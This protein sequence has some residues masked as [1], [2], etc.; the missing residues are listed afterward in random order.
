MDVNMKVTVKI[1]GTVLEL[2]REQ[3][4]ELQSRLAQQLGQVA[5]PIPYQPPWWPSIMPPAPTWIGPTTPAYT[6]DRVYPPSH[7]IC[8]TSQ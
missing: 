7:I 8:G 6:G 4:L 1:G 5:A 2:T 3:A